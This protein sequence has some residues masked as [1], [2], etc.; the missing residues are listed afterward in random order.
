MD[1]ASLK[2][3][4][5]SVIDLLKDIQSDLS[6][7]LE[8]KNIELV[9]P[10]EDY[11]VRTNKGILKIVLRNLITNAIKFSFEKSKIE[12]SIDASDYSDKINVK[13]YGVGMPDEVSA[14]LFAD[15]V[16]S[17]EGTSGEKGSGVGLAICSDFIQRLG[18]LIRV[19]SEPG[20]GSTFSV[21]L[22]K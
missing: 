21:E 1:S 16:D 18:G 11:Q 15:K 13:D 20:K 14:K 4:R 6:T 19:Q 22:P 10:E 8:S 3:E 12:L 17:T 5:F 7:R 9:F 2:K